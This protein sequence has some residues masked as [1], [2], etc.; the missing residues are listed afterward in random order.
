MS[1]QDETQCRILQILYGGLGG[2][3][4]VAF[5]LVEGLPDAR[6]RLI[7]FGIEPPKPDYLEIC[8]ALGASYQSVVKSPGLDLR[9]LAAVVSDLTRGRPDAIVVHSPTTLPAAILSQLSHGAPVALVDHQPLRAK[10]T[11][12][13]VA[14]GA[15]LTFAQAVVFLT[16]EAERA[17]RVRL[18]HAPRRA[19][20]RI[21]PN[22]IDTELFSPG[23]QPGPEHVGLMMA[24]R[25]NEK[26]DHLTLLEAFA[27]VRRSHPDVDVRL[28]IAGDGPTR[29]I[30]EKKLVAMGSGSE[31]Q[32]TGDLTQSELAEAM[33]RSSIYVHSSLAETM[34]T[35]VM[36]AMAAGLPVVVTDV[37]GMRDLVVDG[38]HG[39][40]VPPGNVEAM[41]EAMSRLVESPDLRRKMGA[42]ARKRAAIRFSASRMAREYG[43][44]LR[45]IARPNRY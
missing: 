45:R 23:A 3:A 26:R 41:S 4:A 6:H 1:D 19:E 11:R 2:H 5:S 29:P 13:W 12:H 31:I 43:R 39:Y 24:S 34:S 9:S 7:F 33:K 37:G 10:L 18:H 42:A 8:E 40:I 35:A 38:E 22:G 16:T 17:A 30:L 21:I 36:Q 27:Q 15:A 32:L 20:V 28:A 44:L 25:L 14:L